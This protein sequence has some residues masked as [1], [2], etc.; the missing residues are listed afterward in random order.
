MNPDTGISATAQLESPREF[1]RQTCLMGP[2]PLPRR[3]RAL[4][5][6]LRELGF[7]V[8]RIVQRRRPSA[9]WDLH[10]G[11]AYDGW[12]P[13]V[14][15]Y[16]ELLRRALRPLG[17]RCPKGKIRLLRRGNR[18]KMSFPWPAVDRR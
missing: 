12:P 1:F 9:Q 8:H 2:Q 10:L 11:V 18:L 13:P 16:R 15:S 3:R 4:A 17:Y 6:R 7:K 5:M 14:E